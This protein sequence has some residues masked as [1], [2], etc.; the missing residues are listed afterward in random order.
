MYLTRRNLLKGLLAAV[1][2]SAR[3]VRADVDPTPLLFGTTPV[4]LDEQVEFLARWSSYLETVLRRPVRFVQRGRYRDILALLLERKLDSAWICGYPY[5]RMR[6]QLRLLAVPVYAG[7]P[8]YRAYLIVPAD[9][10]STQSILDLRAQVFAYSDPDSNSGWL[11]PQVELKRAGEDPNRFFRKTFYTWGHRKVIEAVAA[12]LAHGG[13][14]DGYVWESMAR[15]YP[16][17]T[18]ATRVAWR[19]QE[20]GFPPVVVHQDAVGMEKLQ[21][22]LVGMTSTPT[23]RNL[24]ARLNLDSFAFGDEE[25]YSGIEANSRYLNA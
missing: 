21:Q 11:V 8:F 25:L 20:Y 19:S 3:A 24:L 15:R 12:G 5:V 13:A 22:A 7:R 17:L 10:T 9:D 1:A 2:S 16:G 4:F 18:A 23:G 6:D 14:V